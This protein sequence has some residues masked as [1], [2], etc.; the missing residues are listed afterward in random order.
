MINRDSTRSDVDSSDPFTKPKPDV[1]T[2]PKVRFST[3]TNIVEKPQEITTKARFE[4]SKVRFVSDDNDSVNEEKGE[5]RE[6]VQPK[7]EIKTVDVTLNKAQKAGRRKVELSNDYE[8]KKSDSEE[9]IDP[10]L[11]SSSI[12]SDDEDEKI[13]VPP[14]SKKAGNKRLELHNATIDLATGEV[15]TRPLPRRVSP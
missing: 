14:M 11:L 2:S 8:L 12:N 5:D 10:A 13:K 3:D 15:R 7:V 4:S 9:T 1:D 6:P